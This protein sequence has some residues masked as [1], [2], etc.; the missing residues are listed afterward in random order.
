MTQTHFVLKLSPEN[1]NR[2]EIIESHH[3]PNGVWEQK[4]GPRQTRRYAE[5]FHR[6]IKVPRDVHTVLDLGC[7]LGD[8]LPVWKAHY[9]RI[10]LFGCEVTDNAVARGQARFHD[11]AKVFKSGFEELEGCY[12]AIFCSHVLEHFEQHVEIAAHL[13]HRCRILYLLTPFNELKDGRALRP[14]DGDWHVASLLSDTFDILLQ[15]GEAESIESTIVPWPSTWF[16]RAARILLSSSRSAVLGRPV[17]QE[18][19]QIIYTIRSAAGFG[20]HP[21]SA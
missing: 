9:P 14:S 8:A 18:P 12:D 10:E 21:V 16:R 3:S 4:H 2:R 15:T 6:E 17:F 1:P 20:P 5:C 7:S 11:I 13:L 19:L